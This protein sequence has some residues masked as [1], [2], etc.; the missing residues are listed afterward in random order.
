MG[1]RYDAPAARRE[2]QQAERS[3]QDLWRA[4]DEG[5]DPTT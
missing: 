4:L 5:H 3:E 2:Q 1:S